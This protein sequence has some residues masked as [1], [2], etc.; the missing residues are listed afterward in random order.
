[1]SRAQYPI[2]MMRSV[3]LTLED[4]FI[5]LTTDEAIENKEVS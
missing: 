5:Q 4:I 3:D 2:L 1:M